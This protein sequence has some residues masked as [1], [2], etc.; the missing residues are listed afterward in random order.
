MLLH[1]PW[2][3]PM[4]F[5]INRKNKM[6]SGVSIPKSKSCILI[7]NWEKCGRKWFS[8]I[9]NGR[10]QPFCEKNKI[11]NK[12]CVFIWNGEKC[13]QK[14]FSVIQNGHRQKYIKIAY[15]SEME[16]NVIE[17]DF[18]LFKMAARG[19]FAKKISKN[20]KVAY[21]S[22][23]ARN[24]IEMIFDHSRQVWIWYS[25]W[26]RRVPQ[27]PVASIQHLNRHWLLPD[28]HWTTSPSLLTNMLKFCSTP[29]TWVQNYTTW[30]TVSNNW[31][32]WWP[33]CELWLTIG[34]EIFWQISAGP[35]LSYM[36]HIFRS[37]N[38]DTIR[39]IRKG[40]DTPIKWY[41]RLM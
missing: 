23:I 7:W 27:H 5:G 22:W 32:H 17:S 39:G 12:S 35:H 26:H 11:K 31:V 34:T 20:I 10:R 18:R 16:R 4:I 36:G 40:I 9:Q 24:A 33:A 19:H 37:C 38:W 8:V 28:P 3:G 21:W 6:D 14:W 30:F 2:G 1:T 15:W 41:N 13:D 25:D 29:S